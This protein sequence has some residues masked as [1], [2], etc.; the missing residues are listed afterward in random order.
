MSVTIKNND[1]FYL[2][3]G[4][5]LNLMQDHVNAGCVPITVTQYEGTAK[6]HCNKRQAIQIIDKLLTEFDLLKE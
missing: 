4:D 3:I 2:L 5:K 1:Y 6:F